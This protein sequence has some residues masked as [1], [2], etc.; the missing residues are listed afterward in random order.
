MIIKNSFKGFQSYMPPA[1]KVTNL[2]FYYQS[3][4]ILNNCSFE[5]NANEFIGVIGPNGGGKTTLLKLL[6]GFLKPSSGNIEITS[7]VNEGD[8]LPIP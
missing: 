5:I 4:G 8:V 7:G 3:V 6:M 1:I 2:S